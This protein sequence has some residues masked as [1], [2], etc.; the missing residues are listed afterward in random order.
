MTIPFLIFHTGLVRRPEETR[1][2]GGGDA[3]F[4]TGVFTGG[5]GESDERFTILGG[6][7]AMGFSRIEIIFYL[8]RA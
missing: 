4:T 1:G 8:L 2:V 5:R 7:L 6:F 3:R